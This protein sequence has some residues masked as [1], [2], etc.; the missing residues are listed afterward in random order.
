MPQIGVGFQVCPFLMIDRGHCVAD[1]TAEGLPAGVVR[2]AKF[3]AVKG[4]HRGIE[5][6][7][8]GADVGGIKGGWG[9]W[10]D[11]RRILGMLSCIAK[12][13]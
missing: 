7:V 11:L 5:A 3:T 2:G 10:F 6:V 9:H 8:P 4:H 1:V 13:L 12:I